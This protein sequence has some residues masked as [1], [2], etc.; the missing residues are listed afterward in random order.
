MKYFF[1][2]K[3]KYNDINKN[4]VASFT[5]KDS[6]QIN[7]I[8]RE[9]DIEYFNA[10]RDHLE[11]QRKKYTFLTPNQI[12]TQKEI[13]AG[14]PTEWTSEITFMGSSFLPENNAKQTII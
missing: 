7:K 2:L 5:D 4:I 3:R 12:S 10:I 9:M 8:I 14:A 6:V 11:A 13:S 1:P